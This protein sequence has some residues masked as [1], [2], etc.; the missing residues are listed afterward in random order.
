MKI[1]MAYSFSIAF[2]LILLVMGDTFL[3]KLQSAV[4]AGRDSSTMDTFNGR[5]GI[6][7]D[8]GYY[9]R[10][11]PILGYGYG[12]FWTPAH[13]KE[14]SETEKWAVPDGHSAYLDYLLT[15]G[16]VSLALYILLLILGIMRAFCFYRSLRNSTF[17]FCAA[18]L[19]FCAL[20]G[21]LES[22]MVDPSV[23]M[24]LSMVVLARLAF[25]C[26]TEAAG[27]GYL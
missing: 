27:I 2:C 3:P 8:V 25:I 6:W 22:A 7:D 4:I 16:S 9:I 5:T 21:L 10:Q 18:L 12:S 13:L 23:L 11:R 1:A 26:P 19:L 20:N 14:V 15:L 24:F 17:A